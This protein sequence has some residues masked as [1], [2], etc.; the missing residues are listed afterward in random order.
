[1]SGKSSKSTRRHFLQGSA[2]SATG[3]A[4]GMNT[5]AGTEAPAP[6]ATKKSRIVM[7]RPA[8]IT[9]VSYP[10]LPKDEP[11]R[12]NKTL[13]RMGEYID[14]AGQFGGDLIAFPET[15]NHLDDWG[16]G[17]FEPLDGP[18]VTALSKKAKQNKYY[19]IVK[20]WFSKKRGPAI[21]FIF[22]LT[23]LPDDVVGVVCGAIKY[24]VKKFFL[25][26]LAGKIILHVALA[27]AGLYGIDIIRSIFFA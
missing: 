15:C 16:P 12:L 14:Q 8:T 21:I 19:K 24:D 1:M 22:A 23:P 6:P 5:L 7:S 26:T 27:Y 4:L 13:Q 11:D 20:S 10:P 17:M 9:V 3:A 25:A 2:L 18:T